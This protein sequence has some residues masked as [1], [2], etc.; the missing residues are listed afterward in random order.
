MSPAVSVVVVNLNRR[1]LL[2]MCLASLWSQSFTD[3]EV[4]V[5]DNGSSDD[6]VRFL[7]A[8]RDRRLQIVELPENQ[9]FAGGCNAGIV[10][11]R[12]RY[13]ATL[14]NDAEADPRW[15]EA[16]VRV[17]ESDSHVGM[18][19]S[20]I[21][22][23]GDRLRID[24]AGHLIYWD[25]L[26]HGRGSGEPDRGQFEIEEEVL[27][28]DGAAALYRRDMLDQSGIF[29]ESFFAYGDDADV[30]LRGRLAGWTCVYAPT[31]IVYHI[32]SATAGKF[33][34]LKAFLVERNRFFVAVK[35]FPFPLLLVSPLF[36]MVRFAFHAYGAVFRVGSSGQ[37]AADTSRTALAVAILKAYWSGVKHVPAMWR[38]RRKIRR[39]RSLSDFAF[40]ALLWKHRIKLRALTLGS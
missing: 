32:H 31:A 37:F 12:G 24:K 10:R 28:P 35:L 40:I 7:K 13:I 22:F 5:V 3:F 30:G 1:D 39:Q 38:A 19:A 23:H 17:M 16:L 15:L 21:L 8:V 11:A 9:G 29:D 6:S 4:V 27:F 33:S 34:G 36:T 14:N 25:G 18:C 2:E 26:N 20:K